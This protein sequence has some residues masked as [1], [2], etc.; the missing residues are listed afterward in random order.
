MVVNDAQFLKA[1]IEKLSMLIIEG[2]SSSDEKSD[3]VQKTK[4]RFRSIG[5][6]SSEIIYV[7][8]YPNRRY[9]VNQN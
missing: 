3:G 7:N 9:L 4:N 8:V 1:E 2:V 5:I 6:C